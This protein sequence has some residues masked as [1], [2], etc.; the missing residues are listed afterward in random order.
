MATILSYQSLIDQNLDLGAHFGG[1]G[2]PQNGPKMNFFVCSFR[3]FKFSGPTIIQRRILLVLAFFSYAAIL[4]LL[5]RTHK[6]NLCEKEFAN[7][8]SSAPPLRDASEMFRSP[9][10]KKGKAPNTPKYEKMCFR[11]FV[12]PPFR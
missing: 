4:W 1:Y 12:A 9:L 11:K 6:S 5:R 2:P 3:S 10:D 8:S 7:L